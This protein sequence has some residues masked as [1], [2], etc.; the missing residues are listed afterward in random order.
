MSKSEIQ[1]VPEYDRDEL[2]RALP[3]CEKLNFDFSPSD[4]GSDFEVDIKAETPSGDS[5]SVTFL[6]FPKDAKV[7]AVALQAAFRGLVI[8]GVMHVELVLAKG[9]AQPVVPFGSPPRAAAPSFAV[10]TA[11]LEALVVELNQE[12]NGVITT[13]GSPVSASAKA[14]PALPAPKGNIPR[15]K[16]LAGREAMTAAL[17]SALKK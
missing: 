3:Y 5:A 1:T 12:H 16:L 6:G 4:D 10:G 7:L 8:P 9:G 13:S 2:R 15:A 14:A 17:A 11:E